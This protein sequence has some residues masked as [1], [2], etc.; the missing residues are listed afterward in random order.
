MSGV[1]YLQRL[2]MTSQEKQEIGATLDSCQE[3]TFQRATS[4]PKA[5]SSCQ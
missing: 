5:A 4:L 3:R 2:G 1:A